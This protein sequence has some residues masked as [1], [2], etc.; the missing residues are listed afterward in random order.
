MPDRFTL[1]T[2]ADLPPEARPLAQRVL[3]VSSDGIGGPFNLLL[4][5]PQSG[6]KIVDLLDHFNGGFSRIDS[7]SR[8]LAVLIL[9]RSAGA[10]YAWWTHERRAI[11]AQQ[12]S[13]DQI[14]ALN[15]KQRPLGLTPRLNAVFDYVTALNRG[16][17]TPAAT[18]AALQS[19][20]SEAEI[21]D[22]ILFCGL[23]TT[24]AL[25]LN[26]GDV[27]LPEGAH[28]SLKRD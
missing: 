13:P 10:R 1:D 26:E 17:P 27:A 8:R 23:Y 12:F 6:A 22:L 28:D 16:T 4:K 20:M 7:D 18:L 15:N 11:A 14:A 3:E 19:E 9:A 2:L 24:I 25:L 5:S 21:V